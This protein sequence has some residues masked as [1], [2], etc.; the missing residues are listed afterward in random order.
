MLHDSINVVR[1][2][3]ALRTICL[4]KK[5]TETICYLLFFFSIN[6]IQTKDMMVYSSYPSGLTVTPDDAAMTTEST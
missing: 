2:A 5:E 4:R 3:P 6:F 1:L